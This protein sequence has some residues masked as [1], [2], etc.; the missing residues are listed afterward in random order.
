MM[1]QAALFERPRPPPCHE[2]SRAGRQPRPPPFRGPL[3]FRGLRRAPMRAGALQRAEPLAAAAAAACCRRR[4]Q[5]ARRLT[6]NRGRRAIHATLQLLR[7]VARR[8][9]RRAGGLGLGGDAREAAAQTRHDRRATRAGAALHFAADAARQGG[10]A[11]AADVAAWMAVAGAVA[12]AALLPVAA[13]VAVVRRHHFAE[14]SGEEEEEDLEDD[15]E[16]AAHNGG[17][18]AWAAKRC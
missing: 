18:R 14:G 6:H 10:V 9:G 11:V 5:V 2:P 13:R 8:R 17:K 16:R 4:R 12:L 15:P 3:L 7:F 1:P